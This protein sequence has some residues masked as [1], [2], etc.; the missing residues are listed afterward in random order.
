MVKGDQTGP[1]RTH[2]QGIHGQPLLALYSNLRSS[3]SAYHGQRVVPE[4]PAPGLLRGMNGPALMGA[5]AA[6]R[7]LFPVLSLAGHHRHGHYP[8]S[9]VHARD[10]T[11]KQMGWVLAAAA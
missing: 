4:P 7:L 6:D 9:R 2:H 1:E 11:G 3:L 5:F 10:D 8:R